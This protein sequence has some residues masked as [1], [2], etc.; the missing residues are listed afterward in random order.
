MLV[1]FWLQGSYTVLAIN[2]V[3]VPSLLILTNPCLGTLFSEDYTA[4]AGVFAIIAMLSLQL[5]QLVLTSFYRASLVS[6]KSTDTLDHDVSRHELSHTQAVEEC[7]THAHILN[8]RITVTLLEIGI[9]SHSIIIGI[10]LGVAS[11]AEFISLLIA[12]SFHQF[13]EG[14]A[15]GSTIA[16][17]KFK[18]NLKSILMASV[19]GITTPLGIGIGIAIHTVYVPNSVEGLLATGILDAMSGG[20]LI[21][22]ALVEFLTPELTNSK[23]FRD[24][25][26]LFKGLQLLALYLGVALMAFIGRY[27]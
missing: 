14:L 11:G 25:S 21:Y 6:V 3:F 22:T 2:L 27:A 7:E 9:A 12:L 24:S 18:S 8:K 16:D 19:Y 10:A 5:I 15:L 26:V 1:L 20:I 23:D 4:F 17:A 13:F